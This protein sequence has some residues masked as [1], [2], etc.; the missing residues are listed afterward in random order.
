MSFRSTMARPT[1][2]P[3][4]NVRSTTAPVRGH[5]D[6]VFDADAAEPGNVHAGFDRDHG[7]L[8]ELAVGIPP[9]AWVFVD[10]QA[11]AVAEA[12]REAVAVSGVV[13][14][15]ACGAI[16]VGDA[17]TRPDAPDGALLR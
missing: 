9:K 5:L 10:L 1:F 15:A 8:D 11:D 13:D 7:A 12:V 14:R 3:A 16:D 17:G 6:H 2:T 4:L